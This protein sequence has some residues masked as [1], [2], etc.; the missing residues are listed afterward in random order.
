M[1]LCFRKIRKMTLKRRNLIL[2]KNLTL[3]KRNLILRKTILILQTK[4]H[5]CF[6]FYNCCY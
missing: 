6:Y 4:T 5:L 3:K 1:N 2:K